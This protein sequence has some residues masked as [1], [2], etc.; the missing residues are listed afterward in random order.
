MWAEVR[1]HFPSDDV[2]E[3]AL[4]TLSIRFD[5]LTPEATRAAGRFWRERRK[6]GAPRERVVADFL[7]A[8]H[9]QFQADALL[10]RDRG[11][12]RRYFSGL[13]LIEVA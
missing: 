8:A 5:P 10:T 6:S 4:G 11:F 13:R 7:I 1:A 2:F 9:A 3:E 12:Y